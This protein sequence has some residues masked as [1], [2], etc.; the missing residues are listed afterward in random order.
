MQERNKGPRCWSIPSNSRLHRRYDPFLAYESFYGCMVYHL[1]GEA[2]GEDENDDPHRE[3]SSGPV[4]EACL[5]EARDN[6]KLEFRDRGGAQSLLTVRDTFFNRQEAQPED[7]SLPV[8]ERGREEQT[9]SE[10]LSRNG[11]KGDAR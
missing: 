11:C 8:A 3:G 2:H 9:E 6:S 10:D 4:Q 1:H 7:R 5:F